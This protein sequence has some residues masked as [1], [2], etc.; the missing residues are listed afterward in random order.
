MQQTDQA[1]AECR[2]ILLHDKEAVSAHLLLGN[3][4]FQQGKRAPARSEWQAVV[5]LSK[6]DPAPQIGLIKLRQQAEKA[7]KHEAEY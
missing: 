1:V 4:L 2:S 3:L 5:A 7:L 6:K